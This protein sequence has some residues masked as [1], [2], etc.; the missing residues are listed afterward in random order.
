MLVLLVK[1]VQKQNLKAKYAFRKF[2]G[3]NRSLVFYV[4]PILLYQGFLP[5]PLVD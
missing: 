1:K 5:R 3:P 2:K 4:Q